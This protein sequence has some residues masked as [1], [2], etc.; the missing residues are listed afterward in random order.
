M[1][2]AVPNWLREELIKK[3]SAIASTNI[4]HSGAIQM[5]DADISFRK[6]DQADN[7]S[8]DSKMSVEEEDD[9]EVQP[10]F[11]DNILCS[12]C[13]IVFQFLIRKT[14]FKKINLLLPYLDK[15]FMGYL[16]T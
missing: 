10:H 13:G 16:H 9:D 6:A 7:Q 11:L 15:R 1:Q 3:K 4:L 12:V 14:N 8:L 5:E 2:A